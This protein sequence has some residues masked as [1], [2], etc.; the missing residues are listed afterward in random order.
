[1]LR[2]LAVLGVLLMATPAAAQLDTVAEQSGFQRTGRYDEVVRLCG[3]FAT[4]YPDAVRCTEFGRTPEG[5]PMLALV[6]PRTGALAPEAARARDLPVLL[7]QGAIHA[8]D[9]DGKDAGF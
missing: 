2:P 8:G 7:A 6:A 5:R 4:A 9:S 1:M 3:A